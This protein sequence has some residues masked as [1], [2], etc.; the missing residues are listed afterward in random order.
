MKTIAFRLGAACGLALFSAFSPASAENAAPATAATPAAATAPE[1]HLRRVADLDMFPDDGYRPVVKIALNGTL[2]Y[3]LIDTAGVYNSIS[4]DTAKELKMVVREG[5]L[6]L[7]HGPTGKE[8]NQYAYG[9]VQLG[10]LPLP[11]FPWR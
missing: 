3:F 1:C 10:P 6:G 8:I 11:K 7:V 9:K 5:E 4:E 2:E